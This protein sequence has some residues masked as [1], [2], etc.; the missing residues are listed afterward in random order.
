MRKMRKGKFKQSNKLFVFFPLIV[1][2][3]HFNSPETLPLWLVILVR[4]IQKKKGKN[5]PSKEFLMGSRVIE[6][7][8][9][10]RV[11]E[12]ENQCIYDSLLVSLVSVKSSLQ[13]KNLTLLSALQTTPHASDGLRGCLVAPRHPDESEAGSFTPLAPQLSLQCGIQPWHGPPVRR[14]HFQLGAVWKSCSVRWYLH[15]L[16]ERSNNLFPQNS[17]HLLAHKYELW[18]S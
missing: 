5:F 3:L 9:T 8:I 4:W 13:K 12:Q 14:K 10:G 18:K 6:L 1:S 15:I 11:A 17:P 2:N 16:E 7:L